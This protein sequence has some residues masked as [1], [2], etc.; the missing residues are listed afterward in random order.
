MTMLSPVRTNPDAMPIVRSMPALL[1]ERSATEPNVVALREKKLGVWEEI[2][3]SEY[4]AHAARFGI[5]LRRL[6]VSRGDRVAIHATN[7]PEWLYSEL[8]I[9]GIGAVSVGIYPTNPAAEVEFL[10]RDCGAVAVVCEDEEQLDKTLEVRD[11]LPDLRFIVLMDTRGV[12]VLDDPQIITYADVVAGVDERD[13]EDFAREV[14]QAAPDDT[15]VIVYTSGTTGPPRGAMLSHANLQFAGGIFQGLFDATHRDEVLSYLPL[16]HIAERLWSIVLAITAGYVVNFGEGGESFNNDLR[17]VQPTFFVGVP[18]VWEK[19]LA[20]VQIRMGDAPLIKRIAYRAGVRLGM[21][22][23]MR[24]MRGR[25][26]LVDSVL[27]GIAWLLVLRNLRNHLGLRRIRYAASGS[28]PIAPQVLEFFWALGVR[29]REGYGQTESTG[30]ACWTPARDVRLGSVGHVV[31]GVDLRFAEDGEILLRSPGVFRGYWNLPQESAEAFDEDGYL[32]TGDVGEIDADGFVRITDRKKDIII[33]AGGKNIS[34]S[35]IENRLKVSPYISEAVVVGDKRPYVVA[36]IGIEEE[37]VGEWA[38]RKR[39]GY[40]TYADLSQQPEVR[41]LIAGVI[42]EANADFA[43]VERIKRFSLLPK[44]LDHEDG[45]VT[46]TRKV[47]RK[48]IVDR[49]ASEIE[50][51][52]RR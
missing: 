23:G 25:D 34:P 30:V 14:E 6:G 20:N 33:T 5:G 11:R 45:E 12:R 46:A 27:Y 21:R 42:E 47:K 35:E 24:R 22:A 41:R 17:E 36:L 52:Y 40:T 13:L 32:R 10:L 15:A 50:E 48:A 31:D 19:L 29:V 26:T 1:L 38:S 16:C 28:A 18:R 7:R 39:I 4:A 43:Q 37:T 9:V 2:R 44:E 49:Y 3:W 51:L 8:G